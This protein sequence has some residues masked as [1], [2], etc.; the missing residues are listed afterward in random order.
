MATGSAPISPNIL[1]FFRVTAGCH[2][3]EGFGATETGGVSG[4]QT[5]GDT[6]LSNVGPPLVCCR[7]KLA[8][9]SEM[10]IVAQRDQKGEV[11]FQ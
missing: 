10:S 6:S 5:I 4:V 11:K 3:I 8:D 9:V 7:Y 1:N 2:V